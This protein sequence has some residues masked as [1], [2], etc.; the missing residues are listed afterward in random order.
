MTVCFIIIA[1]NILLLDEAEHGNKNI[2]I[3]KSWGCV[4]CQASQ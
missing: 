1:A 3:K 4:I 2:I